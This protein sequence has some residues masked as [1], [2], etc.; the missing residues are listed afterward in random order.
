MYT[1]AKPKE[2]KLGVIRSMIYAT[3]LGLAGSASRGCLQHFAAF[4]AQCDDLVGGHSSHEDEH[5]R[6]MTILHDGLYYVCVLLHWSIEHCTAICSNVH[7][8]CAQIRR[9][10]AF[11]TMADEAFAVANEKLETVSLSVRYE[12]SESLVVMT[13]LAQEQR[14]PCPLTL[15]ERDVIPWFFATMH[16]ARAYNQRVDFALRDRTKLLAVSATQAMSDQ[17]WYQHFVQKMHSTPLTKAKLK[18][19]SGKAPSGNQR[20]PSSAP[21]RAPKSNN[22]GSGNGSGTRGRSMKKESQPSRPSRNAS[23]ASNRGGH[24]NG[25]SNRNGAANPRSGA[26]KHGEPPNAWRSDDSPSFVAWE[27]HWNRLAS[28]HAIDWPSGQYCVRAN[29]GIICH[30]VNKP[31]GCRFAHRCGFCKRD[32]HPGG[33]KTCPLFP[34]L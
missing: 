24:R 33:Y 1:S 4:A 32:A 25:A 17:D 3:F 13:D 18:N 15:N 26:N 27:S 29:L 5:L 23:G 14:G 34:T 31:T 20:R 19:L 9:N 8:I 7:N 30:D 22:R 6:A 11:A 2:D 12:L 10:P 28:P 21:A 16:N